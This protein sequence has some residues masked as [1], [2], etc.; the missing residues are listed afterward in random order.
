MYQFEKIHPGRSLSAVIFP[1]YS[2]TLYAGSLNY[3]PY[4]TP[5]QSKFHDKMDDIRFNVVSVIMGA[6][7][8]ENYSAITIAP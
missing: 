3:P 6:L 1:L 2:N 8:R 4:P 7:H 5:S